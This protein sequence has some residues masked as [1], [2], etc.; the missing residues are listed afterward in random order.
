MC[1]VFVFLKQI[2]LWSDSFEN[3]KGNLT[4]VQKGHAENISRLGSEVAL[5]AVS[6]GENFEGDHSYFSFVTLCVCVYALL[7]SGYF[8]ARLQNIHV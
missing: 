4:P 8:I 2:S 6:D 1:D 7:Q 5:S 3:A